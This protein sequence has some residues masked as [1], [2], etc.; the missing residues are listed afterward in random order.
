MNSKIDLIILPYLQS[1]LDNGI[2]LN[3]HSMIVTLLAIVYAID[4]FVTPT[5]AS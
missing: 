3:I 2:K 1:V 5:V 4:V